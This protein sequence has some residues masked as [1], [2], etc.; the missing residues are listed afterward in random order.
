M[1]PPLQY[2]CPL[3][4]VFDVPASL[5]FYR[6]TLGM[7]IVEAAPPPSKVT[8]DEFG[9]VWLQRDTT[10]LMLNSMYETPAERPA[11]ADPARMAAH[12]DTTL[13][14]GCSDVDGMYAHLRSRGITANPPKV[15]PYGMR[16]LHVS[17]PDGFSVCF[18]WPEEK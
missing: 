3:L 9:W 17:D 16:Q 10:N 11:S 18:Q 4:E 15:A 12:Q 2:L 13:Y 7:K 14:F 6:D 8:D 5:A 1:T